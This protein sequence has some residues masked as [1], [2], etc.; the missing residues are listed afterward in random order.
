MAVANKEQQ[1][2]DARQIIKDTMHL[3]FLGLKRLSTRHH[4][5][6]YST[7]YNLNLIN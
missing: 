4:N 2:T 1:P 5:M 7:D 3:E 6:F